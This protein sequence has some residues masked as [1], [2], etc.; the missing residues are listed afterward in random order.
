MPFK[1]EKQKKLIL[2]AAHNPEFAKKVGFE[3]Q[4]AKKFIKDTKKEGKFSKIKKA[5]G[6]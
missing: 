3:Q 1:S 2:A 6:K 4:A 5:L